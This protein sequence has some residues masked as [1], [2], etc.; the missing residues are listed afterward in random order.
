MRTILQ[1]N[2]F[3]PDAMAY[4]ET[5]RST[6][7]IHIRCRM[8]GFWFRIVKGEEDKYTFLIYSLVLNMH[9]DPTLQF[10]SKWMSFIE[11]TLQKAGYGN[12][13]LTQGQGI[14]TNW[15]LKALKLR[16]K[17]MSD[18]D[19]HAAIWSNRIC[20]NYKMMKKELAFEKY[21][22]ILSATDATTLCKFRCIGY[23]SIT[24]VFLEIQ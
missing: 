8:I 17:D 15:F 14:G 12:I 7:I 6:L 5:G 23:P 4:G 1:V 11:D 18:Q 16:L 21:F 22:L 13:F 9:K 20:S 19:W 2:K 24:I 10:T 3:T